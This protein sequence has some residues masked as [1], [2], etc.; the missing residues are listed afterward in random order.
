MIGAGFSRNARKAGLAKQ[1]FPLWMDLAASLYT[2]LY[3]PADGEQSRHHL[4]NALSASGLLRIAQEYEAAFGRGSLHSV[5][6]ELTPDDGHVPDEMHTRL[7]RLPWRDIFTTNWDTLLE[8][9]RDFV[10]DRTYDIV[11]TYDE[12]PSASKPR[13]VKLHGSLPAHFPFIATEE[14]SRTYPRRFAPFVNTVQQAMMET[15]F[16]LIGFSGDDPNFL[17]WS[18]WVR[19]NLGELAPKIYL[20][21]WLDLSP[22]RRRMLEDRNVVPIDISRHQQ[23]LKWP[24]NLRHR[25]ATEWILHTLE[26][27]RPYDITEWPSPPSLSPPQIP[28]HLQPVE[29]VTISAPK[30]EPPP[31]NMGSAPADLP[32]QVRS[33]IQAWKHNRNVYP[34]W[35]VL[36]PAR[37]HLVEE[38]LADWEEAILQTLPEFEPIEALLTMRELVWR[39][40]NLLE[41]LSEE[42]EKAVQ[43]ALCEVDCGERKIRGK[44]DHTVA[45]AGIREA[46]TDLAF[47]LL[48]GARLRFDSDDFERRLAALRPFQDDRPEVVQ[49][50]HHEKCLRALY[51][52]DFAQLEK[53]LKEW[54]P[55]GG[56]PIWMSRK[57][58]ILVEMGRNDEAVSL[59]NQ[60]LSVVREARGREGTLACPSREGWILCFAIAFSPSIRKLTDET[61]DGPP[62]FGRWKQLAALECDA[63]SQK[64][65]FLEA[66]KNDTEEKEAPLFDLGARPGKTIHFSLAAYKRRVAANQAV[67][68]CEVAGLPPSAADFV[69]ASDLLNLAADHLVNTDAALTFRMVLRMSR[70]EA[71]KTFNRIWTR[72]RI[73]AMP[74]EHVTT[75]ADSISSVISYALP[76][77]TRS[78]KSDDPWLDRLRIATEALSRLALRF[79]SEHAEE[80]L[81]QALGYYQTKEMALHRWLYKPMRH[82][83]HRTWE[84]IP[85]ERRSVLVL[86]LLTAPISGINGFQSFKDWPDPGE[87]FD[88]TDKSIAPPRGPETE[89]RWSEV[90]HMIRQGLNKAGEPR[91]RAALRLA[92]AGR[93]DCF[94]EDER[95]LIAEALWQDHN[96]LPDGA[97]LFDWVFLLLPEPE[98]GLAEKRFREKW[99]GPKELTKKE[100]FCEFFWKLGN[101]FDSLRGLQQPLTL[102]EEECSN[103]SAS[104]EK[105]ADLP[106]PQNQLF[107]SEWGIR[108]AVVGLQ[109][110]LREINLPPPIAEKLY[111]R[112]LELN[113]TE[114]PGFQLF[115]GLTKS[116][117]DRLDE[118][119]MSMRKGLSSEKAVL[120]EEAVLGLKRWLTHSTEKSSASPPPPLDLLREA[121]VMIATRRRG[122]LFRALE[123][124][125]RVFLSGASEQRD[126]IASLAIEGMRYLIEELRYDRDHDEK[127]EK[128]IPLLR[129]SCAHLALAMSVSGYENDPTVADWVD[130]ARNDPLPEVRYAER[131]TVVV[132][133]QE[134]PAEE[135]TQEPTAVDTRRGQ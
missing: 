88:S 134:S 25:Y 122:V 16:C 105:W 117:P 2:K 7:L 81:R 111:R 35:L 33:I 4:P 118:L 67:R 99:L 80:R 110:I 135:M 93:W 79:P 61:V 126:A 92:A 9:T 106:L 15:V 55:E 37:R 3:P 45:W 76:R 68:L 97:I 64:R 73:A 84:A 132:Q 123:L 120:A 121:G 27:G 23:A 46:W 18:G 63:F 38:S 42:V 56:D 103:I 14:D 21:G 36:P 65:R 90:A 98:P 62:P 29:I 6:K 130:I 5:I 52:L 32:E 94:T 28:E 51:S 34:G 74:M 91:S 30:K 39:R 116:L 41:P 75:L 113:Q 96:H 114:T 129:W 107:F 48:T 57:A 70:S 13:I 31:P 59:L 11:R 101:A 71:D 58:A 100:E 131:P 1:E 60:S 89:G 8:R 50:I 115:G 78:M 22:H 24:E 69:V 17:N 102:S 53:L 104:I 43:D 54:N 128:D 95:N 44:N 72:S 119:S 66:L 83:L 77:F 26:H 85:K 112:A 47:A 109:S 12:I 86:D 20:A 108:E 124:A 19:D 125:R 87:L 10:L 82:L 49:R 133:N 40:E 127:S